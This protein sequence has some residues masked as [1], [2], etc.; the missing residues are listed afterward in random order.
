MHGQNRFKL[1]CSYSILLIVVSVCMQKNYFYVVKYVI[2]R[3]RI[4]M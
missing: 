2:Q 3:L 1:N 4:E